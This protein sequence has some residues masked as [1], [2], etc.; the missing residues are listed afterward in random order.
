MKCYR[1]NH[2]LNDT[3]KYCSVCGSKVVRLNNKKVEK[4]NVLDD[5]YWFSSGCIG[6]KFFAIILGIFYHSFLLWPWILIGLIFSLIGLIKY[7]DKR[8]IK[9]IIID[10]IIII[11][12]IALLI[13]LYKKIVNLF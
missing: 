6:A 2:E 5:Y 4:R 7:K 3:D 1:C 8:H 12:E 10:L 13:C 9:L 11:C